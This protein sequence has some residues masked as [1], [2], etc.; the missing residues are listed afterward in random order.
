MKIDPRHPPTSVVPRQGL[1]F[2]LL[3]EISL[4]LWT[5]KI[6][7]SLVALIHLL[8]IPRRLSDEWMWQSSE[9]WTIYRPRRH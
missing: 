5:R 9:A 6:I 2:L 1:D 3:V 4:G 8:L 7:G